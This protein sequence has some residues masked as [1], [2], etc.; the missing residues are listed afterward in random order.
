MENKLFEFKAKSGDD[1]KSYEYGVV[2]KNIDEA[3]EYLKNYLS[4]WEA[5]PLFI[6]SSKQV[7]DDEMGRRI[8]VSDLD[9]EKLTL[10]EIIDF[11]DTEPYLVYTDNP[12]FVE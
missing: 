2:S 9:D 5:L 8:Y 7:S 6:I 4:E 11:T 1:S 3:T 10:A 12:I